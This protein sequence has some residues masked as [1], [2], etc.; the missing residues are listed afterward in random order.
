MTLTCFQRA[1]GSSL[2]LY[3]TQGRYTAFDQTTTWTL[4][5]DGG[6][7]GVLVSAPDRWAYGQPTGGGG[8][9]GIGPSEFG[10]PDPT[11]GH[12]GSNV[13]GYNLNGDYLPSLALP[14][15]LTTTAIN[16][17]GRYGVTLRW[18]QWLGVQ[19]AGRD[20]AAVWVSADHVNWTQVWANPTLVD[21]AAGGY[22]NTAWVPM[23]ANVSAVADN[24]PTVY[25]RFQIGPTDDSGQYCGWNIDDVQL[26]GFPTGPAP[27]ITSISQSKVQPNATVQNMTIT[28]TDFRPGTQVQ[29]VR[30]DMPGVVVKADGVAVVTQPTGAINPTVLIFDLNLVGVR[31]GYWDVQVAEADGQTATLAQSLRIVGNE[32]YVNDGSQSHDLWCTAPGDDANDG[33]SPATPKASVQSV[34]STYALQPGDAVYVDTGTYDLTSSIEVTSADQGSSL[35]PVEFWNSPYG[36]TFDRGDNSS[37]SYGWCLSGASYVNLLTATDPA[38]KYSSGVSQR[39]MS[40]IGFYEGVAIFGGTGDTL[41]RVDSSASAFSAISIY[42]AANATVEDSIA[43]QSGTGVRVFDA[44]SVTGATPR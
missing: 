23:E 27:T 14:E 24:Q 17:T 43:R 1:S 26:M 33:L 21:Y 28:G 19:Q 20:Q 8:S 36:V 15:Y 4:V 25:V 34:L 9:G 32:Y 6:G 10:A 30:A 13:Y 12:T 7:L 44:Q 18:W 22:S 39:W 37:A 3:A 42:Y 16:C 35:A 5:G 40:V 38:N 31:T 41:S 29:L 11:S 2:E